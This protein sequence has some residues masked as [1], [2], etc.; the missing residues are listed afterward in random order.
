[1][2]EPIDVKALARERLFDAVLADAVAAEGAL[3]PAQR[4][5]QWARV[6]V[7]LLATLVTI[8]V[9]LLQGAAR[10]DEAQDPESFDPLFPRIEREFHRDRLAV[11]LRS[12]ERVRQLPEGPLPPLKVLPEGASGSGPVPLAVLEELH[13]RRG[14]RSLTVAGAGILAWYRG[15]AGSRGADDLL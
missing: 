14:V 7:V 9:A 3:V 15:N 8:G 13:G 10:R 4:R 6:A 5:P 1:M 11:Q 2:S 12:V